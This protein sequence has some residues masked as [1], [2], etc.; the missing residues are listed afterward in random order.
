MT[1]YRKQNYIE[2]FFNEEIKKKVIEVEQ[3]S[4]EDSLSKKFDELIDNFEATLDLKEISKISLVS[5]LKDAYKK[6]LKD[7]YYLN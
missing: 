7:G 4:D 6:G 3:N 1:F 5:A 2:R